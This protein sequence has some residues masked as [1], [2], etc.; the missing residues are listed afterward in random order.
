MNELQARVSEKSFANE[1]LH[2]YRDRGGG[3]A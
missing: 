1:L 2:N 3:F